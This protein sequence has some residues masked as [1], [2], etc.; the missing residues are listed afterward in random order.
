MRYLLG[1][2]LCALL[3]LAGCGRKMPLPAVTTVARSFGASDTSY[4]PLN[5][6]WDAE[7]IGY[8]APQPMVPTDIT[9]GDD[10]YLFVADSAN[11]RVF[12]L[13]TAGQLVREHGLDQIAPVPGPLAVDIDAKLNLLIVTGGKTVWVWNQYLHRE[14]V[15]SI[16][17]VTG[18]FSGERAIIDSV[19]GIHP[20]YVDEGRKTSF[21]GVA[22]GP[23]ASNTV[24]LTDKGYNRILRLRIVVSGRARLRNGRV[25]PTFKGV[26]DGEVATY[27]SGAGTVDNPRG[28]TVDGEGNIY[29]TQLGGN[30][31]VQKLK[32]QGDFYTSAYTLYQHPIMD[33]NRFV[34]PY[35]VALDQDGAI[36]VAD[37]QA[38]RVYKFFNK[39]GR[40]G[41]PASLGKTGLGQEVF[42]RPRGLF[43]S[44]DNVVY[45]AEADAHRIRRFRFSVSESDLPVEQP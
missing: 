11:D 21:Q 4:I 26:Y 40:A 2:A 15:D 13:T 27:G 45:V 18:K 16:A 34:G 23:T 38:G 41:H 30:F 43:V 8:F 24:F 7:T 37:T 39:G 33:L 29:F 36:F 20:F 22:F 31:L 25:H 44:N 42:A 35:D 10:G 9:I 3:A 32:K 14:E 1:A 28:L 19:L 6:V 17:G 12:V 5:P